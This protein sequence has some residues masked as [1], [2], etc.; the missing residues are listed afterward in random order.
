MIDQVVSSGGG[1]CLC[2]Q[3]SYTSCAWNPENIVKVPFI[4]ALRS[5]LYEAKHATSL[6]HSNGVKTKTSYQIFHEM[7]SWYLRHREH[8]GS[9]FF[10]GLDV[11]GNRPEEYVSANEVLRYRKLRDGAEYNSSRLSYSCLLND[12]LLFWRHMQNHGVPTPKIY[13]HLAYGKVFDPGNWGENSLVKLLPHCNSTLIKERYGGQ[14]G[15]GRGGPEFVFFVVPSIESCGNQD[16]GASFYRQL[17]QSVKSGH[18]I[19]QELVAQ[20][21]LIAELNESSVNTLRIQS[22]HTAGKVVI[23]SMVL[24]VGKPGNFVDSRWLGGYCC[25]IDLS[26][27]KLTG[28]ISYRSKEQNRERNPEI[29]RK[30][31]NLPI[32]FFNETLSIIKQ[33]HQSLEFIPSIGWDVAITMDGPIVIEGNDNWS[34]ASLQSF[35]GARKIL[36]EIDPEMFAPS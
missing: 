19:I 6:S 30:T 13:G 3:G 17:P 14:S 9:Y 24:R 22:F 7:L 18:W 1:W 16:S 10:Y 20:H 25:E 31:C 21:P 4:P 2:R 34:L 12:K 32:P 27:G 36:N 23:P 15:K 8:C 28:R 5:M 29:S 11:S 35:Q 33:A 26:S